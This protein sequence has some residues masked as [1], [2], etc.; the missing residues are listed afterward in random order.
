MSGPD[1]RL[2]PLPFAEWDDHTRNVL[3]S[4]LRR[5]ELYLSGG[6]D[7]PPMPIVLELL[8]RHVALS[9]SWLPFTDMLAGPGSRLRPD[10]REL[11]ILRVAVQT[12]SGYEWRQH[13]RMGADTGLSGEQ[14]DAVRIGPTADVW[15]PTERAALWATD[16]ML[17]DFTVSER[18]WDALAT[19]FDPGQL[20]ELLFVIGGYLCLATVLNSVGLEAGLPD[21][22]AD[23]GDP[24]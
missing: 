3:L 5:P 24:G 19:H 1:P 17:E 16:E 23:G 10:L 21:D 12:R 6:P 8:A 9:E 20:L 4:H 11:L 15:T 22:Q 18:T 14:I 7:A 2:A 13:R